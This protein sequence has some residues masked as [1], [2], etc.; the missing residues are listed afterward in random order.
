MAG[1]KQFRYQFILL[2]MK[3]ASYVFARILAMKF[4]YFINLYNI[5]CKCACFVKTHHFHIRRVH[6]FFRLCTK[7]SIIFKSY[8]RVAISG[9]KK[10]RK[11]W[12]KRPSKKVNESESYNKVRHIFI[13]VIGNC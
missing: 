10:Y 4:K 6:C 12:R 3:L 2:L 9:I 13:F 1:S 11:S 8:E 5:L 7:Y